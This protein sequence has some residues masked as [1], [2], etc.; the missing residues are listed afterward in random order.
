MTEFECF[1]SE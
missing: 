1:W